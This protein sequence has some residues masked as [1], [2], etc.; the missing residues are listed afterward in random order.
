M[1]GRKD[2]RHSPSSPA[3]ATEAS[4]RRDGFAVFKDKLAAG[5]YDQMLGAGLGRTLRGA[6]ADAGLEA[7]VGALRLALI[8]LLQEEQDPSRLAAG[9]ARVAGVAVQ[10]ARL[11]LGGNADLDDLRALLLGELDAIEREAAANA[12]REQ[13]GNGNDTIRRSGRHARPDDDDRAG[14]GTGA[15]EHQPGAKLGLRGGDP[16]DGSRRDRGA[17]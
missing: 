7:E 9:V 13:E 10:A 16:A 12:K 1:P 4:E 2:N 17:A 5:N 8:R 3:E 15:G 6:A 11:R 14:A